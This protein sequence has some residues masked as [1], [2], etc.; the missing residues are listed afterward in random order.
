M[1]IRNGFVSNSS[2]SS[3]ALDRYYVSQHQLD[4]L[5][6]YNDSLGENKWDMYV[7]GKEISCNT[8]MDNVDLE[9]FVKSE[10]GVTSKAFRG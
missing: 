9:D 6:K 2:S 10:L 7:D 4:E 5:V 8:Y 3:F 1:K